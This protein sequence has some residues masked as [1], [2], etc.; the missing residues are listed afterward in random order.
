MHGL[1]DWVGLDTCKL[2]WLKQETW[3]I[4]VN[5]ILK[6]GR[7]KREAMTILSNFMRT[8][9]SEGLILLTDKNLVPQ[10]NVLT[11]DETCLRVE[12]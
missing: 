8:S 6:S 5:F 3:I 1:V 12:L 10:I 9:F 2:D 4:F 11:G 7:G